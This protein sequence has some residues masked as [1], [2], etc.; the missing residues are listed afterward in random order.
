M[1]PMEL[2]L[3]KRHLRR[4]EVLIDVTFALLIWDIVTTLPQPT[5]REWES[6]SLGQFLS[7]NADLSLIII[8]VVIVI[9]YWARNNDHCGNLKATNGTHA[10]LS[11]LQLIT[12][13]LYVY[14]VSL[15]VHFDGDTLSLALQSITL[16]LAG[17][18]GFAALAYAAR[19]GRLLADYTTEEQVNGLLV[20]ALA[21]PL[22]ALITLPLASVSML[23]WE[24]GWLVYIPLA[25]LL[26]RHSKRLGRTL[27]VEASG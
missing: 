11:I 7:D 5:M 19:S 14:T 25:W 23:A 4:L 6:S 18:F 3:G 15:G 27:K 8:G 26:G 12:L 22:T 1:Q 21:E 9:S 16:L 20:R 10:A 13:L 24:L 2:E 17:I